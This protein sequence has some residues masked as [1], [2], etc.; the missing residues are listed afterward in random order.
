MNPPALAL[1]LHQ[2]L[3][4]LAAAEHDRGALE[5]AVRA[6]RLRAVRARPVSGPAHAEDAA[7]P[8]ALDRV[9]P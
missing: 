1:P 6:A 3:P 9:L 4:D 5:D 2:A 8:A 7:R